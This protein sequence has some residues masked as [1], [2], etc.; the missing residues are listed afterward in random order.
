[1]RVFLE[2]QLG[3]VMYSKLI[4]CL[5]HFH[6]FAWNKSLLFPCYQ[7]IILVF[8]HLH[9]IIG[10]IYIFDFHL[11]SKLT[12]CKSI[13]TFFVTMGKGPWPFFF[14]W[15]KNTSYIFDNRIL[16]TFDGYTLILNTHTPTIMLNI[17]KILLIIYSFLSHPT[18]LHSKPNYS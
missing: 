6:L 2:S 1:M 3:I 7:I 17:L 16:P 8:T 4:I 5:F 15:D 9:T 10:D 13:L 18:P 14:F 11:T 12:K